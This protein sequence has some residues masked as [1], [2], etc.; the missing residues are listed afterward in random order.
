MTK[1]NE[2]YYV[3]NAFSSSKVS[4]A[5][6]Y[7]MLNTIRY[8]YDELERLG[9]PLDI[10]EYLRDQYLDG[11]TVDSIY[12]LIAEVEEFKFSISQA[13]KLFMLDNYINHFN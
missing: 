13:R 10:Y 6:A 11:N 12:L 5:D 9:I 7:T 1:R 3:L 4:L 2:T 8:K